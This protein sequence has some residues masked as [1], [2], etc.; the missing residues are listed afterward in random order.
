MVIQNR[1]FVTIIIVV[2]ATGMYLTGCEETG[3][4]ASVNSDVA[5]SVVLDSPGK[6]HADMANQ[7]TKG[8]KRALASLRGATAAFHNIDKANKAGYDT[9]ITPCWYHSEL[10]AMGYHYGNLE[11]L[12]N[13]EVDLLKPEAL[14]YEPGP[15][16]HYRLVGMEYIV[17]VAAWEGEGNPR[18][19]GQEYHLNQTLGLY[20]LHIWLWRNNPN[21]MFAAWNP[22]VTCEYAEESEDRAGM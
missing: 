8:I 4:E 6:S 7:D 15:G 13:G 19:L 12:E 16:G 21:G 17:P 3:V 5:S 10:G 9:P 20:T 2:I 22:K 1:H 11:Y 18:L 14:M